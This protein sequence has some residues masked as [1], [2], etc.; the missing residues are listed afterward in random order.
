[1]SVELTPLILISF[2]KMQNNANKYAINNNIAHP[3]H[4]YTSTNLI[5]S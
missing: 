3:L 2:E 1:M 4:K 5:I